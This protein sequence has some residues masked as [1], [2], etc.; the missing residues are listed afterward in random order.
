MEIITKKLP[1]VKTNF[2]ILEAKGKG[3]PDVI[4]EDIATSISDTFTQHYER[5][6]GEMQPHSIYYVNSIGGK[7]ELEYGD[8][9]LVECP[10]ILV[11]GCASPLSRDPIA[12]TVDAV[13]THFV[14]NIT[15]PLID[16]D[17]F[18]HI[19]DVKESSYCYMGWGYGTSS[20]FEK[21]IT[22]ISDTLQEFNSAIGSDYEISA[23]RKGKGIDIDVDYAVFCAEV[24]DEYEYN[25]LNDSLSAELKEVTDYTVTTTPFL[26]A[27]GTRFENVSGCIGRSNRENGLITPLRASG[28]FYIAPNVEKCRYNEVAFAIAEQINENLNI[29][30]VEVFILSEPQIMHISMSK[31]LKDDVKKAEEIANDIYFANLVDKHEETV[32]P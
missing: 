18:C 30:E 31:A 3:H 25:Y 15:S 6:Y 2:E 1:S 20:E 12:L 11:K 28:Y 13:T 23:I 32:T 27:T 19:G 21:K 29:P 14:E 24:E 22:L 4:C 17:V 10:G 26:T 16:V 5:D 9:D 8:Y 7:V